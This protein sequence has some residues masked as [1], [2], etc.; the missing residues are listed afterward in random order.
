M[1]L[2][3]IVAQADTDRMWR[4]SEAAAGTEFSLGT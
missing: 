4:I 2:F 1:G 3:P